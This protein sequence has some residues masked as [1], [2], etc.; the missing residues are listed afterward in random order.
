[1]GKPRGILS[2]PESFTQFHLNYN[3]NNHSYSMAELLKELQ[4]L[5]V[6][7]SQ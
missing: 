5:K 1:M 4:L 3:M 7:L 2:L 6:S